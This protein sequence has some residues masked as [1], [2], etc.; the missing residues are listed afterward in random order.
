MDALKA[1]VRQPLTDFE[2]AEKDRIA[3][4][5]K[6]LAQIAD[7]PAAVT[8]DTTSTQIGMM[9]EAIP[10]LSNRDWGIDFRA[11]AV[12]TI[13]E[14]R[15]RLEA[16]H[17]AAV[18]RED[19][20]A[21]LA[22][23]RAAEAERKRVLGH[24][25]ALAKLAALAVFEG[26]PTAGMID[27]RLATLE[28][29]WIGRQWE[30]FAPRS[31]EVAKETQAKLHKALAA[32]EAREAEARRIREEEI[33]AQAAAKAR[34]QAEESA[35]A[36]ARAAEAR[37]EAERQAAEERQAKAERDAREAEQR[38]LRAEQARKDAEAAAE[39]RRIEAEEAEARRRQHAEE[40]ARRDQEAAV[41]AERRRQE[42]AAAAERADAARRAANKAHRGKINRTAADALMVSA[43]LSEEASRAV[44]EA[45]ARAE[46]PAVTIAY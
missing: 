2:N 18:R 3:G 40:Q 21:E 5:E 26:L 31:H 4:H 17:A 44:V 10:E 25:Q 15:N 46:V 6:A 35:A 14:A 33:A 7:L 11:R 43:N 29:E 42:Q 28:A 24:E 45:I 34:Q 27:R 37:A 12:R 19:E 8:I 41:A 22:K 39:R 32:A 9:L 30:D 13:D 1:R 20:A 36:A 23:L 38:A 16:A